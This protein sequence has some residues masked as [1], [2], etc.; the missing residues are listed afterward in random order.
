M[1]RGRV[2]EFVIDTTVFSLNETMR[3]QMHVLC[4]LTGGWLPR[5]GDNGSRRAKL[6]R[7][8]GKSDD[9]VVLCTQVAVSGV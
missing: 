2:R 3:C 1:V 9:L 5:R 7:N 8:R 6:D 4:R